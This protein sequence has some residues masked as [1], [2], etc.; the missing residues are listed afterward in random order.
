MK[1]TRE[2]WVENNRQAQALADPEAREFVDAVKGQLLLALCQRAGGEVRMPI[3]EL[4]AT[5]GLIL[6][7]KLDGADLILVTGKKN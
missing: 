2:A 5:G 4:D 1:Q 7:I 6:S 3:A